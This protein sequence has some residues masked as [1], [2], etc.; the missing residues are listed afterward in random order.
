MA[1]EISPLKPNDY[2]ILLCLARGT[3]HGY[4]IARE[5]REET[6]GHI[7]LEAGNL[8]RTLQKLVRQQLVEPSDGEENG[9]S[10]AGGGGG[11]GGDARRKYYQITQAGRQA[12][13]ADTARMRALVASVDEAELLRETK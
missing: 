7:L 13:A 3:Q 5:I 12:L 8:H 6:D 1:P 4:A 2:H 10:E 11:G 9:G